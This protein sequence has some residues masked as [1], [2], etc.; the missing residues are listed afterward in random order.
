MS[1]EFKNEEVK[2]LPDIIK[3]DF[4][5]IDKSYLKVIYIN[6]FLLFIPLLVGLIILHH[7]FF[8]N[9]INQYIILIY[10]LFIVFFGAIFI[11]LNLSFPFRKYALREKDITYKA[12]L[13]VKKITTVPFSRVQHVEIDEKPISRIFGLS[14]I[15]VY[16]AGDSSDDLEIKGIKKE[17]ALQIKEFISSKINE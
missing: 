11:V 1:E 10:V 17:T 7:F 12:G 16:T 13:L 4:K 14:S 3:V 15:S 2:I 6:F 8:S 5:S 9:E